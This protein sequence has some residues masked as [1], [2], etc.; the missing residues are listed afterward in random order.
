MEEFASCI[1]SPFIGSDLVI[2][3]VNEI[4]AQ[5]LRVS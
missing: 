3:F 1:S 2:F 4:F 5:G